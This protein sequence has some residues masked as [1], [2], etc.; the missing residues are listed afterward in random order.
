MNITK[1][2]LTIEEIANIVD[3]MIEESISYNREIIK[4]SLVSQYCT[5]GD[6]TNKKDID[7]YNMVAE[8]GILDLYDTEINNY[9][10]IDKM[11]K[12][13]LGIEKSVSEF[14]NSLNIK[15]DNAMKN[16]PKDLNLKDFFNN[17]KKVIGEK[18]ANI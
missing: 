13:E 10:I 1:K 14:L 15:I 12:E 7:I 18:D 17:L 4:V 6:F 11:V 3:Q 5:D 8:N 9:Y 2:F 16:M